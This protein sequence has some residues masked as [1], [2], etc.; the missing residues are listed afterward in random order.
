MS[1]VE[2]LDL[3]GSCG[4]VGIGWSWYQLLNTRAFQNRC[5]M[6]GAKEQAAACSRASKS[7]GMNL[8]GHVACIGIKKYSQNVRLGN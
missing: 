7:R 8:T 4:M 1:K 6:Y 5:D 2:R 3:D